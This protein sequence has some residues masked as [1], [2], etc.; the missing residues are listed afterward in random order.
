M[1]RSSLKPGTKGLTRSPFKKPTLAEVKAKQEAKRL[2]SVG[3][4]SV[5]KT[6]SKKPAQKSV[7]QLKKLADKYFSEY[8]RLRDSNDEGVATCITCGTARHWKQ[9]QNG[10]FVSRAVSLLRY[11]EE[12]CNAQ[13]YACNVM[14]HGDLYNYAI[15]LDLKYGD[16]TAKKLHDQRFTT[17]KFTREELEEVIHD[18]KAQIGFYL[19]SG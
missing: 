14:K 16:G 11:D 5:V 4:Q 10:H 12:N 7:A 6:K 2:K 15:Q 17:H 3:V 8:I 18:A 9:M 13:D 19:K 1:K